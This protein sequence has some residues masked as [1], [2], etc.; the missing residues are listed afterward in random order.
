[1]PRKPA[2]PPKAAGSFKPN[3][4]FAKSPA[5]A[6]KKTV[7]I[8]VVPVVSAKPAAP[9]P[10]KTELPV[11]V[12]EA[13]KPATRARSLKPSAKFKRAAPKKKAAAAAKEE[14]EIG[15]ILEANKDAI[16]DALAVVG[17]DDASSAS[18]SSSSASYVGID[19]YDVGGG[20]S[21]T[22][23][24]NLGRGI[25]TAPGSPIIYD[26]PMNF[27]SVGQDMT[28]VDLAG[29]APPV[30]PPRGDHLPEM[31]MAHGRPTPRNTRG[32]PYP[33]APRR[34]TPPPVPDRD[35]DLE[36][37]ANVYGNSEGTG[38]MGA[39]TFGML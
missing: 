31:L 13:K 34:N 32:Q 28:R 26:G 38:F 36:P 16:L 24:L 8:A 2:A 30:P 1:M 25:T 10:A 9:A 29:R 35:D 7:A 14:S 37:I 6:K 33:Q 18:S 3:L 20:A 22:S 39:N 11:L 21:A 19:N 5:T 12:V 15:N 23:T 4:R 17:A 27:A